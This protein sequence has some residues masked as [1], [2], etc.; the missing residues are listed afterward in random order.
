MTLVASKGLVS[1]TAISSCSMELAPASQESGQ[2]CEEI[3][4]QA[5]IRSQLRWALGFVSLFEDESTNQIKD[6]SAVPL[7]GQAEPR[8][9][10]GDYRSPTIADDLQAPSVDAELVWRCLV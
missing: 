8:R 9:P 3:Y 10:G 7:R 2:D 5:P 1:V 4:G 6:S